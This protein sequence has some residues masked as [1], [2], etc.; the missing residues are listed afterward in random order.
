M[1]KTRKTIIF[2]SWLFFSTG[3]FA[4]LG[5]LYTWGDGPLH[6][7][8]DL[9]TALVPWADLLVTGPLSIAAAYGIYARKDWGHI[10]GLMTSGIYIFGSAL[11]YIALIWQGAPYPLH[12]ALPPLL[13]IGI[14]FGYPIWIIRGG[15]L[16]RG[17]PD[18]AKEYRKIGQIRIPIR[19][20][21]E[22][23]DLK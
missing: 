7:E 9:L 15:Y 16:Y 13:G 14:G 23:P 18:T 10:T 3:I 21:L 4:I 1:N 20:Q 19:M 2:I 22:N 5:A 6:L 11:V 8:E 17:L 12:L